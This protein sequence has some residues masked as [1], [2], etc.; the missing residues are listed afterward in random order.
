[1][2][3][4][5]KSSCVINKKTKQILMNIPRKQIS[6]KDELLLQSKKKVRWILEGFE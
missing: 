4:I 2:G 6:A 5:I 1:M 3:N